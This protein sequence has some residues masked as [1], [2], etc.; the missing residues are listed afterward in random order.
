VCW[1]EIQAEHHVHKQRSACAGGRDEYKHQA[2]E[3]DDCFSEW[4]GEG[5]YY[6]HDI[7]CVD[8]IRNLQASAHQIEVKVEIFHT[9]IVYHNIISYTNRNQ[10]KPNLTRTKNNFTNVEATKW[11]NALSSTFQYTLEKLE[12][13]RH[14]NKCQHLS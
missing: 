8:I 6:I 5:L 10:T 13:Y 1:Q 7:C 12:L 11:M 4:I 14:K 2:N 9:T 3:M